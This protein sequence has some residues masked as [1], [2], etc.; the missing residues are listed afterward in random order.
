[1]RRLVLLAVACSAC[2][3]ARAVRTED[4]QLGTVLSV[5]T[6]RVEEGFRTWKQGEWRTFKDGLLIRISGYPVAADYSTAVP[7]PMLVLGDTL[8]VR[9]PGGGLL[10]ASPPPDTVVPLWWTPRGEIA[11]ELKGEHLA[12][13]RARATSPEYGEGLDVR[14]P[15][16]STP[17]KSYQSLEQLDEEVES[18][19]P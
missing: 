2:A 1:M 5:T 6:V 8:I 17:R 18:A 16:A 13:L 12:R 11:R 4:P 15:P 3:G 10:A 7:A 14:T 9:L 19:N